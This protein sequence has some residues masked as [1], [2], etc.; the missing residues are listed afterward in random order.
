MSEY[1]RKRLEE[2]IWIDQNF[3]QYLECFSEVVAHQ[4]VHDLVEGL[5]IEVG[6]E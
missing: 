1:L 4:M 6:D 3:S 2:R 5:L